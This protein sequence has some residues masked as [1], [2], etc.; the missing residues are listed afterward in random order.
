[1]TQPVSEGGFLMAL[2]QTRHLFPGSNTAAGFVGFFD[3]LRQDVGGTVI[4]K[5]GPG[6]GKSTLM[7]QVGQHYE[8]AG[9]AVW[10]YHCSGDPDSLDAVSVPEAAFLM[11]DGTSPHVIDPILPGAADG[12]LNLGV[13]L[14]E[15]QLSAY[16]E[17][18]AQLGREIAGDYARAYRYLS[19]AQVMWADAVAVHQA[20]FSPK[21]RRALEGEL[22][23]LLPAA[24]EGPA[25]HAYAQ[26][27]TYQGVIQQ[28]D[29]VLT[30]TVYCI[31]APWGFD[32]GSLLA[33]VWAQAERLGMR[34]AAYHDPLDAAALAHVTVGDVTLTSAVMLDAPV[35]TPRL[36]G[37]LLR[38]AGPRLAFDR[39]VYDL[40][41][42]QAIDA[43]GEAKARH[44]ALERYYIDAM[45][46]GRLDAIRQEFMET[47]PE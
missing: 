24:P 42:N 2:Q 26:A 37:T 1:M 4:L 43:L 38:H 17:P 12:I 34:R 27:I 30:G 9:K 33:P 47:L 21:A 20:A 46:Y 31:D 23:S 40:C 15:R 5:G 8:K 18:I 13:C 44:D 19:A 16:R 14:D 29:S 35:L 39:A 3:N 45:D 10:Y 25:R 36:D 6:V 28:L 22:L 11:L 41:L 7:R 32:A